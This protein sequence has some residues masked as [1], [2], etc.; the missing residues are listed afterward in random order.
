MMIVLII[1][2]ILAC[3]VETWL[4]SFNKHYVTTTQLVEC[5]NKN[6]CCLIDIRTAPLAKIANAECIPFDCISQHRWEK[7]HQ[8]KMVVLMDEA[9]RHVWPTWV[10]VTKRVRHCVV[11]KGGFQA[12]HA[13]QLPFVATPKT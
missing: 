5:L 12:W 7:R 2:L 3:G 4:F 8:K 13:A 9:E 1:L 11:L 6:T 10:L